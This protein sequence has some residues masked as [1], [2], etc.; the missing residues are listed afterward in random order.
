VWSFSGDIDS[1]FSSWNRREPTFYETCLGSFHGS[2][3]ING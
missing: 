3:V 1:R 2:E